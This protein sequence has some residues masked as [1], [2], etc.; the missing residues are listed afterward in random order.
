MAILWRPRRAVRLCSPASK[1]CSHRLEAGATPVF[2]GWKPAP[3]G[4]S[5]FF[6]GLLGEGSRGAGLAP[7]PGVQTD[8]DSRSKLGFSPG[9]LHKKMSGKTVSGM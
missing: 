1:P 9:S 8:S 3:N 6:N 2:T 5:A 4:G 7:D